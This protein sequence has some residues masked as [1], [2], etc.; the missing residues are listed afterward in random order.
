MKKTILSIIAIIITCFFIGSGYYFDVYA[1][2]QDKKVITDISVEDDFKN[3]TI[4]VVL[5]NTESLKFKE[6]TPKDFT[7]I[8]C[9]SVIDITADLVDKLKKQDK[10]IKEK[11]KLLIDEDNFNR[12]LEI[13]LKKPSKKY[14]VEAIKK[15]EKRREVLSAE[16]NYV[17]NI[18]NAVSE[19][20]TRSSGTYSGWAYDSIRLESAWQIETGSSSVQIG[21]I[22][23]GIEASHNDLSGQINT[24]LSTSF[25]SS[26]NGLN[27]TNSHGTQMAGIIAS[28]GIYNSNAKGVCQEA[29]LVSLQFNVGSS[30]N[31]HTSIQG[32][33]DA[34]NYATLHDIEIL[35]VSL[36]ILESDLNNANL[37]NTLKTSIENYPGL[38][39]CAAGNSDYNN[40]SGNLEL[41][42]HV[43]YYPAMYDSDNILVVGGCQYNL[44]YIEV[45]YDFSV[46]SNIYVDILA[47]ADRIATTTT[48]NQYA[49]YS[50]G[51]SCATAFVSG[52]A[53]LL[54]SY[55]WTLSTSDVKDAILDNAK[56]SSQLT[57]A[58]VTGGTLDAR[59]A[60]ESV[61]DCTYTN[62]YVYNN[63][64]K[65]CSYCYCGGF[66]LEPHVVLASDIVDNVATCI[67]C[68][69]TIQ[70]GNDFII[71]QPDRS[72]IIKRTLNG[73]YILSD[74]TI[75]LVEEDLELFYQNNLIFYDINQEV[76]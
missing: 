42:T 45:L 37:Y 28:K 41:G 75:V 60:L 9:E 19:E 3:D 57:Y 21:I 65:H 13:K 32:V 4:F 49:S 64:A 27:P 73:S 7:D 23:T 63:N 15:L 6:Y 8:E 29:D 62:N 59:A 52:V 48:N 25:H 55:D 66:I 35:N 30:L 46:Y 53:G 34:V 31:T 38:V 5:S 20:N 58:C 44:D 16:P 74:G 39:V 36:G 26:G 71:V 11:G 2:P 17:V 67:L 51:T 22:D 50:A 14:V 47:P 43:L 12:I 61:H 24:T 56:A 18:Q 40:A 54:L 68:L 72:N 70:I 1:S 10:N 33:V 76:Q 69:R